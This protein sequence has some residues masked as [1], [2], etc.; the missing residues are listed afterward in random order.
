MGA[1][2][3][4]AKLGY[5]VGEILRLGFATCDQMERPQT[6]PVMANNVV[7]VRC[8]DGHLAWASHSF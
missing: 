1:L 4:E 3:L 8:Q 7:V 6:G 2:S 5:R